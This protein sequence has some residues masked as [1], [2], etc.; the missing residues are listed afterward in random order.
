MLT[1]YRTVFAWRPLVVKWEQRRIRNAFGE[2]RIT[3]LQ[4]GVKVRFCHVLEVGPSWN[5]V[6][7][8]RPVGY[9]LPLDFKPERPW[10]AFWRRLRAELG[11]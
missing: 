8:Y 1:V 9:A 11:A 7:K 3:P 10:P 2:P 4:S 6:D 5:T